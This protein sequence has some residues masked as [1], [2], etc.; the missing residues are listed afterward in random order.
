MSDALLFTV[1]LA[2]AAAI[3][4]LLCRAL[5]RALR[6]A[7]EPLPAGTS[8]GVGLGTVRTVDGLITVDVECISGQHFVGRLGRPSDEAAL[9]G[10]RPGVL[11]LVTFDPTMRERLSL[12]DDMAAVRTAFDQMLVRKG[13][14]TS[15]QMDLI[16]NGTKSRCVVTAMRATGAAREDYREVELDLMV[17]RPAG[18][19]FPAHETA[20][21]P[22][23]AMTKVAPGSVVDAYYRSTD[24]TA[25][26]V[27]VPP[28]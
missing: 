12:A 18:G 26:A 17:R 27:S 23:S 11:L 15:A 13:L 21:I 19:Q 6:A 4:T 16:R 3:G 8:P 14:V 22:E 5:S 28:A 25:V 24:E 2:L 1:V 20:L 9:N 7:P 10:M